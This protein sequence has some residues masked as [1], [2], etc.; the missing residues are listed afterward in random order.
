MSRKYTQEGKKGEKNLFRYQFINMM[1]NK[2]KKT[3]KAKKISLVNIVGENLYSEDYIE[4]S[5]ND[6]ELVEK[7]VK[8]KNEMLIYVF[9]VHHQ[10]SRWY[11]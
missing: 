2:R 5:L 4:Y 7:K 9:V 8:D 3:K 10:S 1:S 6:I 11:L